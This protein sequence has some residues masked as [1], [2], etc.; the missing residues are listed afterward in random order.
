MRGVIDIGGQT[1]NATDRLYLAARVP[2]L[3][4]WGDHDGIIPVRHGI[5]AHRAIASSRLEI[6]EGV[7]HFPHVEAPARFNEML[8]DFLSTTV[9]GP[10][11]SEPLRASPSAEPPVV[12][13][14]ASRRRRTMIDATPSRSD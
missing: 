5:D 13:G 8:L 2:T 14:R 4:V 7:G 3:I 9:A 1:V 11:T 12:S 10:F 6:I